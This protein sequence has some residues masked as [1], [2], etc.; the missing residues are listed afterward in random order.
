MTDTHNDAT[1]DV[2]RLLA[3]VPARETPDLDGA[4]PRLDETRIHTL[5]SL[6]ERRRVERGHVLVAEGEPDDAFRVVLSGRVA[7][8]EAFGSLE[9]RV[10]RCMGRGGSWATSACSQGRCPS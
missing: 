7:V 1:A 2:E 5:S 10:V 6:G 9:Q 3:S 4:F 8:V